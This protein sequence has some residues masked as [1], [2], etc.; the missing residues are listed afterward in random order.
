[1]LET[2]Y[3]GLNLK[4][5][6]IIGSSG[7]TNSIEK[8]KRIEKAGAGAIV[9]KSLFEEQI[10]IESANLLKYNDYPEAD[11]YVKNFVKNNT[12]D[13]YLQLIEDAKNAVTIPVIASVNCITGND[14]VDF[15][16][17]AEQAGA[18]AL[19]INMYILPTDK[20]FSPADY[21]MKYMEI[22]AAVL[23]KVSIPVA[24][25]IASN[26]TNLPHFVNL[27]YGSG[28]KA[29][30]LFN[31]YFE[32]DIDI[33]EMKFTVASLFSSPEDIRLSLRWTG[34]ISAIVPGLD[35]SSSTGNHTGTSVIKQLLAG[36]TTV[37]ICSTVYKNGIDVISSILSDAE[38]WMLEKGFADINGFRGKMSYK[39]ISNPA[40]YERTQ[41]IKHFTNV[42]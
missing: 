19:E 31:R 2:K 1:M 34:I 32:P 36:A 12:V 17:R 14:W 20:N 18:D 16:C 25:K 42:V 37:Q 23:K 7:L 8:I 9:L 26:F 27:L 40:L 24:A 6:L 4:N 30:V 28:V 38:K 22:I 35:I 41:F 33:N 11:D 5:P 29:V 21:E 10:N 13:N 3:M 39:N 15:A